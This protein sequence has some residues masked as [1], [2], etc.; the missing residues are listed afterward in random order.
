MPGFVPNLYREVIGSTVLQHQKLASGAGTW[1]LLHYFLAGSWPG[2]QNC[3]SNRA[4][5]PKQP[6]LG[7]SIH[8]ICE[9]RSEKKKKYSTMEA[10][11]VG[12][13]AA[14]AYKVTSIYTFRKQY[15]DFYQTL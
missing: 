7:I 6:V 10:P 11:L 5:I 9:P 3:P 15:K 14:M 12:D 8:A 1:A 4:M 13:I 2:F